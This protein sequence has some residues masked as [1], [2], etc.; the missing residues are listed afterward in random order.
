MSTKLKFSGIDFCVKSISIE[1]SSLVSKASL[2]LLKN[3]FRLIFPECTFF[4]ASYNSKKY[5]NWSVGDS[6]IK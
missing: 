2:I 5:V 4:S 1:S 3:C 6:V